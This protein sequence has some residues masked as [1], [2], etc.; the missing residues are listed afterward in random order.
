MRLDVGLKIIGVEIAGAHQRIPVVD[1]GVVPYI[2]QTV[3]AEGLDHAVHVNRR[4]ARYVAQL[5]LRH[6][7]GKQSSNAAGEGQTTAQW[8]RSGY[9]R[10]VIESVEVTVA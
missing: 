7:E 3:A 4:K 1:G 2:C 5:R 10:N 9:A 6:R 8:N